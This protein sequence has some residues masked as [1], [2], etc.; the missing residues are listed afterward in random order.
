MKMFQATFNLA[1]EYRETQLAFIRRYNMQFRELVT[2]AQPIVVTQTK[3]MSVA[4]HYRKVRDHAI[5]TYNALKEKLEAA[6]CVCSVSFS[7]SI[8]IHPG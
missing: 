7:T 6:T 3:P 2:G 5:L 1:E 8:N 4:K